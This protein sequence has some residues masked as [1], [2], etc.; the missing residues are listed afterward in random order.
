MLFY[1]SD[2]G[3]QA[4]IPGHEKQIKL[5]FEELST[6]RVDFLS[7]IETTTKSMQ[8][9]TERFNTWAEALS[10]ELGMKVQSPYSE[11]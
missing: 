10:E 11:N 2:P 9:V 7:S 6:N 1:F 3:V 4:G 8:S 5:K